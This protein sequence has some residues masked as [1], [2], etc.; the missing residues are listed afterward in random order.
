MVCMVFILVFGLNVAACQ[1]PNFLLTPVQLMTIIPQI[2]LGNYLFGVTEDVA[3]IF[4]LLTTDIK[5]AITLGGYSILRGIVAW[6][7]LAPL[8]T[9]VVYR[10]LLHF[11]SKAMAKPAK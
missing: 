9:F 1:L 3:E 4:G 11:V 7:L 8:F 6:A 10:I 5:A 2:S